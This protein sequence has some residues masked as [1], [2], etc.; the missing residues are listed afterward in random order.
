MELIIGTMED[1]PLLCM[2]FSATS[3]ACVTYF[4]GSVQKS[5]LKMPLG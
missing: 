5:T 1:E 4:L 2:L 3:H